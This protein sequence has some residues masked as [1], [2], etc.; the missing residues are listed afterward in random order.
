MTLLIYDDVYLGHRAD[1]SHPE[2]PGR[3][4][5]IVSALEE[6]GMRGKLRALSP[7]RASREELALAHSESYIERVQQ[8]AGGGVQWLDWDT[9]VC[10]D[11]WE[12]AVTAA[13]GVLR[14]CEEV[15]N[16][17][18]VTAFCA[19][20]PPGHHASSSRGM[21]FCLFNNVAIAARYVQREKGLARVAIVDWDC[22]HGNGTA[23][24]FYEDPSVLYLS[25]HR[26]PFYPGTGGEGEA[27]A[28]EG[29]GTTVNV[30]L[31]GGVSRGEYRRRFEEAIEGG[32]IPF[33]PE[34]VVVSAGF[35]AHE[36]DPIAG[37]GLEAEDFGWM[38]EKLCEA[39]QGNARGRIVSVLEGGYDVEALGEC[40]CEHVS[41]LMRG[42]GDCE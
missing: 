33:Q 11:S 4:T 38:T 26:Y 2:N 28:G 36:A 42:G 19:V 41:A 8:A 39:A 7:R 17:G 3:L 22:H 37:L 18:D 25:L 32:L 1:T 20:R 21:G 10:E 14:A 9:Y 24:I 12:A 30:P 6:R 27:G 31:P 34:A 15:A 5:A 35:D 13:G 29:K 23:E 40:V 16:G